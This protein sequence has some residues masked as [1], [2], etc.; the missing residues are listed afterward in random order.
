M[1]L[2]KVHALFVLSWIV[3]YATSANSF[4]KTASRTVDLSAPYAL[5]LASSSIAFTEKDLKKAYISNDHRYYSA[6]VKSKD[7]IIY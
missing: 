1:F 3:L 6:R 7:K 5:V 4:A 2:K